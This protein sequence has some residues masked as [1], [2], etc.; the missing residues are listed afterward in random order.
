[1]KLSPKQLL[2]SCDI[3]RS[4]IQTRL[5]RLEPLIGVPD[6][7]LTAAEFTHG[8]VPLNPKGFVTMSDGAIIPEDEMNAY[9]VDEM[10]GD[11]EFEGDQ[12]LASE[13]VHESIQ[14]HCRQITQLLA[15][16]EWDA[17]GEDVEVLQDM[18][19]GLD[20]SQK[21]TRQ[22]PDKIFT[23]IG[24]ALDYLIEAEFTLFWSPD[25]PLVLDDE[26]IT[27]LDRKLGEAIIKN[28]EMIY[29]IDPRRFEE[30]IAS[31]FAGM[32]FKTRLTKK[33]YDDGVDVI[34]IGSREN[35]KSE[36][37]IQCKRYCKSNTVNVTQV[38]ELLGT[39][40]GGERKDSAT[41]AILITTSNL[42]KPAETFV[43]RNIHEM[44]GIGYERLMRMIKDQL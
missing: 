15:E 16:G 34:A 42:T 1:M 40:K 12:E 13:G 26:E 37:L 19:Y 25:C 2:H 39:L 17:A 24:E 23:E 9:S 14:K 22:N 32:G 44:D 10:A 20:A 35:E 3:K 33:S 7:N 41:R 38:R 11:F 4:V 27:E 30:F 29:S 43:Q 5:S 18:I 31:L 8:R 36:Y 21:F 28:P 6:R